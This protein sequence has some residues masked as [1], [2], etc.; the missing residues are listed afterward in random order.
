MLMSMRKL[1][2]EEVE[3]GVELDVPVVEEDH[4]RVPHEGHCED[5]QN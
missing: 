4:G 2:E 5:A 3:M 1:N